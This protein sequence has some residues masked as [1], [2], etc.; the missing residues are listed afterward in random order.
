MLFLLFFC[1]YVLITAGTFPWGCNKNFLA[2]VKN[3]YIGKL[4]YSTNFYLSSAK[5][6]Q[7]ICESWNF[8]NKKYNQPFKYKVFK[9]L[10]HSKEKMF[11]LFTTQ[12]GCL[13]YHFACNTMN[14]TMSQSIVCQGVHSASRSPQYLNVIKWMWIL[15]FSRFLISSIYNYF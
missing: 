5:K 11:G 1:N 7:D 14:N 6:W 9:E 13:C 2:A 10:L 8:R 12:S 15:S 3:Y 4:V